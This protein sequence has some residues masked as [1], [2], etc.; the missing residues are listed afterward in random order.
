MTYAVTTVEVQKAHRP[1][2]DEPFYTSSFDLFSVLFRF[3]PHAMNSTSPLL[4]NSVISVP[5]IR[6][7]RNGEVALVSSLAADDLSVD[8][9]LQYTSGDA[10][11]SLLAAASTSGQSFLGSSYSF[12]QQ[13]NLVQI[14]ILDD[15]HVELDT[16]ALYLS[17][18]RVIVRAL[19]IRNKESVT[20]TF[21]KD[22]KQFQTE[23]ES[24]VDVDTD[25]ILKIKRA[26]VDSAALPQSVDASTITKLK[27]ETMDKVVEE[28]Q[29]YLSLLF[30]RN[31]HSETAVATSSPSSSS[32][33]SNPKSFDLNYP[34]VLCQEGYDTTL[35]HFM[36][37]NSMMDI[38]MIRKIV[39]DV[40]MGLIALHSENRIYAKLNPKTIVRVGS[41]WK[42][43]DLSISAQLGH[44]CEVTHLN[45]A[46]SPP[47]V[48]QGWLNEQT[49]FTYLADTSYDLWSLGCILFYLIKGSPLWN[50]NSQGKISQTDMTALAQWSPQQFLNQAQLYLSPDGRGDD[51]RAVLDLLYR[52]LMPTPQDRKEFFP[53]G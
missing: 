3:S 33:S 53:F 47:E 21:M 40:V 4:T 9:A 44:A 38:S 17:S 7:V 48:A 13:R 6:V 39:R 34:F 31:I 22:R 14:I 12:S 19:D 42:L 37:H 45:M 10:G 8:T 51:E 43:K 15:F 1:N 24:R 27:V 25:H 52:L 49:N 16:P 41:D 46:H 5:P 35:A 30:T 32:S 18:H 20:L 50:S 36:S 26:I 28:V 23:L 2:L 11:G 29:Q